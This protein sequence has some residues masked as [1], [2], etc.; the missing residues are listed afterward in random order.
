MGSE[1]PSCISQAEGKWGT[2]W[3]LRAWTRKQGPRGKVCSL[4]SASHQANTSG[5]CCARG[6]GAHTGAGSQRDG[7]RKGRAHENTQERPHRPRSSQTAALLVTLEC[8]RTVPRAP[9]PLPGVRD[10]AV[11]HGQGNDINKALV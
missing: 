1:L 8:S 10:S 7:V 5:H 4:Q 2:G 3:G 9:G 6:S 11:Q